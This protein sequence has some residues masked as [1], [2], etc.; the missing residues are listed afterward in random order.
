MDGA[1]ILRQRTIAAF[2]DGMQHASESR[3]G[4]NND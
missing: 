1:I 3:Q 4:G 2:L